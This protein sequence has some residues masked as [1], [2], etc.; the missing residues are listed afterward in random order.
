MEIGD[1][2]ADRPLGARKDTYVLRIVVVPL[3]AL[4]GGSTGKIRP[5]LSHRALRKE[6]PLKTTNRMRKNINTV[7]NHP[8]VKECISAHKRT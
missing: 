5:T 3:E 1:F 6:K 8:K 2:R 4:T 7:C